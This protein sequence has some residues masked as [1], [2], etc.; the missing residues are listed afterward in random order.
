MRIY[1]LVFQ[2]LDSNLIEFSSTEV[3]EHRTARSSWIIV[4]NNGDY[5]NK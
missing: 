4:N 3:K 5:K 2:M 1:I